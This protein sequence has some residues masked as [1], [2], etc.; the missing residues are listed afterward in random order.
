MQFL[1]G[2][3]FILVLKRYRTR[4]GEKQYASPW[5]P[6]CFM[7]T[8]PKAKTNS[9]LPAVSF[10]FLFYHQARGWWT[11]PG[12]AV[13]FT[14]HQSFRVFIFGLVQV[15]DRCLFKSIIAIGHYSSRKSNLN[16]TTV[17]AY[18]SNCGVQAWC[19]SLVNPVKLHN[20]QGA[21]IPGT[22]HLWS[23]WWQDLERGQNDPE[24]KEVNND[25]INW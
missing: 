9:N 16:I 1:S 17:H 19:D 18:R 12:K 6:R 7:C 4:K 3:Q 21:L 23:S 24:V 15:Y 5:H 20:K 13:K 22:A 11:T 8:A 10:S 25:E 14:G 2:M